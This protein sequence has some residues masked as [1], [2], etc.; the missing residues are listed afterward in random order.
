MFG[1]KTRIIRHFEDRLEH[2]LLDEKPLSSFESKVFN[3]LIRKRLRQDAQAVDLQIP[4]ISMTN[5]IASKITSI[6]SDFMPNNLGNWSIKKPYSLTTKI[7]KNLIIAIKKYYQCEKGIIG[8]FGSGSTEGNIYAAWIGR[9][10]VMENLSLRNSEKIVFL[11]SSLAHYSMDKAADLVGIHLEEVAIDLKRFSIDEEQ[12]LKTIERLYRTGMRGFLLP[13]T[14]GYTVSGTD[15]N[16][17]K[18]LNIVTS[19]ENKYKNC[20]F[21]VWIDAAFS[22]I[23]KIYTEE[24]FKPFEH[25]NVQLITADFHK[26]LAVPYPSSIFLYKRGLLKYI[27]KTIP[28]IDQ[29]DTT[30]LGSRPGINVLVT[31]MT[32]RNL[33]RAKIIAA[34]QHSLQKKNMF[35]ENVSSNIP[36]IRVI[37][38]R[39]SFQ[40]CLVVGE[41]K[42]QQ[43]LSK[44]Y[45]L[46]KI[47]YT[48]KV[49]K[50]SKKISLYKLYF[51]PNF[52]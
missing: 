34:V 12:L 50:K 11:K 18:I 32:L 9:N 8:H 5:P 23:S 10:Y 3:Y 35:L 30:L 40:A 48:V 33:G 17:E 16:L 43:L 45:N 14:L 44:K 37:N 25:K 6:S 51:L 21:F 2:D 27:E 22:G 31:W 7:E 42:T 47:E 1:I 4:V 46:K 20:K 15:D 19:T 26:F 29:M 36:S 41:T 39:N 38:N 13:V 49:G 28:Y 24:Y 52:R